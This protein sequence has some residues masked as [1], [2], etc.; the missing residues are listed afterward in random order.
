MPGKSQTAAAA[1]A[2]VYNRNPAATLD[3]FLVAAVKADR[4]LDGIARR[5]FNASYVLPLKRAAVRK[6]K[7]GSAKST[8]PAKAKAS[9]RNKVVR[10]RAVRLSDEARNAGRRLVFERDQKVLGALG[11]DGNPQ[12]AYALAAQIDD[13]IERLA[14]ALRS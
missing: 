14:A 1:V 13:Y 7:L 11:A 10:R 6:A 4:T 2:A 12:A 5:S 9:K 3:D 8:K